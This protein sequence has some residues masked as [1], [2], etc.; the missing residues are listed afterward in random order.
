MDTSSDKIQND[1]S[2]FFIID[3][4]VIGFYGAAEKPVNKRHTVSEKSSKTIKNL[5]PQSRNSQVQS[6]IMVIGF[7]QEDTIYSFSNSDLRGSPR[8]RISGDFCGFPLLVTRGHCLFQIMIY[9]RVAPAGVYRGTFAIFHCL[10]HEGVV[11]FKF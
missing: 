1:V 7:K 3:F 2:S 4:C 8:G 9:R 5:A 11:C 6:I 10:S